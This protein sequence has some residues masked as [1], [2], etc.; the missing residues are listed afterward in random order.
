MMRK[1]K[2][3]KRRGYQSISF[4]NSYLRREK[5]IKNLIELTLHY[6]DVYITIIIQ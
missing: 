4:A 1:G 2:K 6:N 3:R 5:A